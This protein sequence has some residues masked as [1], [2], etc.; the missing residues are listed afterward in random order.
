MLIREATICDAAEISVL[1]RPLAEKYIACDFSPD[2]AQNL[3]T[4]MET[5]AIEGYFK[6]GFRYH[7]AEEHNVLAG[8]VGVRDS[9]HLYHLFVADEFQG[10]GLARKLWRIA[11]DTCRQAG[12]TGEFTVNSSKFAVELYR[13]FGFVE[14]G[15]PATKNG[16][17]S[18]P[19]RF[20]A[21]KG[22]EI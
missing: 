8:V 16:V 18:V 13:T 17:T 7:V 3:L 22:R 1:I 5:K 20:I 12:N 6:S 9:R 15:P 4:S 10:G 21:A 19:M 2:G 11:L 14:S